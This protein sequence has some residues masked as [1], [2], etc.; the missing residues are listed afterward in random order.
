M[1]LE[2]NFDYIL[3]DCPPSLVADAERLIAAK[4]GIIIPVQSE[5]LALEG[6]GQL[7]KRST[8]F[9]AVSFRNSR[10]EGGFADHV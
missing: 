6:L 5:Y 1:E 9:A 2:N 7:T 3:I 10:S 8:A 4:D